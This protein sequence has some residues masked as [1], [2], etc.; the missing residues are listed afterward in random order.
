M[1]DRNADEQRDSYIEIVNTRYTFNNIIR[2]QV[3]RGDQITP[4]VNDGKA[5]TTTSSPLNSW[6]QY[7]YNYKTIDNI[8][9]KEIKKF[10][11]LHI[12]NIFDQVSQ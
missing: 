5:Q 10:F 9:T 8:S 2:K 11:Q 7:L 3:S 1:I 6:S 4:I 12:D